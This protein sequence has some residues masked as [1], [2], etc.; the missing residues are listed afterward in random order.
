MRLQLLRKFISASSPIIPG[1]VTIV[2][3]DGNTYKDVNKG[4]GTGTITIGDNEL[5]VYYKS[6]VLKTPNVY[7]KGTVTYKYDNINEPH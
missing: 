5:T 6:G 3:L 7:F 4:D 2:G 1:S